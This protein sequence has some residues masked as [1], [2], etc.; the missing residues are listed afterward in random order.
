MKDSEKTEE[1]LINELF[2]LRKKIAELENAKANHK[3][4]EKKLAKS[5]ELYRL[6]AENTG[7][8]IAL[9]TFIISSVFL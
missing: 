1:R 8:V 5:E 9:T 3:Q 7:D 2:D 6:I 4:T